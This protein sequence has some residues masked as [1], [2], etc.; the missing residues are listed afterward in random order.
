[1]LHAGQSRIC[2]KISH[3]DCVSEGKEIRFVEIRGLVYDGPLNARRAEKLMHKRS[4]DAFGG[5]GGC[6]LGS[7]L[8]SS[9]RKSND[10]Q[11]GELEKA[12]MWGRA[13]GR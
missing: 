11:C 12:K 3:P 13:C 7:F 8:L 9:L 1:M 2:L 4:S 10:K 5:T 6:H